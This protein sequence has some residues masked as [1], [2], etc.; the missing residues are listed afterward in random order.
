MSNTRKRFNEPQR[1]TSL[2]MPDT[3]R[4]RGAEVKALYGDVSLSQ[5]WRKAIDIGLAKLLK[6]ARE[7]TPDVER[8]EQRP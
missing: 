6:D 2:L 3:L 7:M 4:R 5:V 8:L 1:I